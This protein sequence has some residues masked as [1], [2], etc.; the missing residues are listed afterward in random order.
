MRRYIKHSRLCLITFPNTVIETCQKYSTVLCIINSFVSV[1]KYDQTL[2]IS[3]TLLID[4]LK[5]WFLLSEPCA[6]HLQ[7][8]KMQKMLREASCVWRY[9]K[10]LLVTRQRGTQQKELYKGF[11][12][13][14]DFFLFF[15]ELSTCTAE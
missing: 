2:E 3:Q 1:W 4:V 8:K 15:H 5:C 9:K 7:N 12:K 13:N 6:V 10:S 11:M 14:S